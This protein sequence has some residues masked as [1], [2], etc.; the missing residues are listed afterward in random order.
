MRSV[1]TTAHH[2]KSIYFN[3][4]S[5]S[6][7]YL[8]TWAIY[9]RSFTMFRSILWT[10]LLDLDLKASWMLQ[11]CSGF[12]QFNKSQNKR[13]SFHHP[14]CCRPVFCVFILHRL[15]W[16]ETRTKSQTMH[17]YKHISFSLYACRGRGVEG[18][19]WRGK[20]VWGG[21]ALLLDAVPLT[22]FTSSSIWAVSVQ[23]ADM[24]STL[25]GLWHY[26]DL[27]GV[28]HTANRP[29]PSSASRGAE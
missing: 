17:F 11:P 21:G 14:E 19:S 8:L 25:T 22:R 18:W 6:E 23:S 5:Y 1:D 2:E 12:L 9:K 10:F 3:H 4:V 16:S 13:P 7:I 24:E 29:H 15:K 28:P 26:S 27:C 20:C